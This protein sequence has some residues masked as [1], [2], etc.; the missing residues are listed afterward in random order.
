MGSRLSRRGD[1]NSAGGAII[2]GA[3]TVVCNGIPVGLHVSP[4]TPH[5]PKKPKHRRAVTVSGSPDVVCEG[6][7]VLRVGSGN[8]CG[9]VIVTGSPDTVVS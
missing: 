1:V 8:S 2:R 6:S 7:P 9:H 5:P 4:I 3:S